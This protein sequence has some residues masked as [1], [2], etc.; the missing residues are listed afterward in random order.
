MKWY[1][2]CPTC[3]AQQGDP[4]RTANT[5]TQ[6][7]GPHNGRPRDPDEPRQYTDEDLLAGAFAIIE[8]F[9]RKS[10]KMNGIADQSWHNTTQAADEFICYMLKRW[11]IEG[12]DDSEKLHGRL[13]NIEL[14]LGAEWLARNQRGF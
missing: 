9:R 12:E 1:G 11:G 4:C 6:M 3:E 13:S 8:G 5:Q 14:D 7:S 10:E 2:Q